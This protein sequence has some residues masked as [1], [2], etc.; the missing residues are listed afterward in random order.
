MPFVFVMLWL[1][2][3]M[4]NHYLFLSWPWLTFGN[5]MS[6][7][8]YFVQWVS[9]LGIYSVSGWLLILG[10]MLN[11][12]I[13]ER[14][15]IKKKNRIKRFILVL[16]FPLLLSVVQ[17]FLIPSHQEAP[18]RISLYIPENPNLKNIEKTKDLYNYLKVNSAGEFI[19]APE[20]FLRS[21]QLSSSLNRKHNLYFIDQILKEN[22]G[23]TF[24]V[25]AEI[26][27]HDDNLF[28]T[29]IVYNR[30]ELYIRSKKKYIPVQEYTPLYF[31]RIF[32]NSFY[33]LNKD[34]D[35]DA[36]ISDYSVLPLLC[37]ESLFSLFIQEN[38]QSSDLIFLLT[39]ED[40]M[41]NSFFGIR[42]YLNIIRLKAIESNRNIVK[43][44]SGGISAVINEKGDVL[45]K[46]TSEFQNVNA[47]RISKPSFFTKICSLVTLHRKPS[48]KPI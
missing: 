27:N 29:I 46:V 48:C 22:Q 35:Q 18:I 6:N 47:F 28:N 37:Y 44:S 2:Y 16:N 38:M 13:K 5:V 9:F 45:E 25:G 21:V 23:T 42:Q 12:I 4:V 1:I 20:L 24:V 10:F 43:C 33:Q 40:F 30:K 32:G 17:Y 36:I 41:N 8:H 34:D 15:N 31:K 19:L 14:E 11:E 3:E 39:S 7:N 26:K